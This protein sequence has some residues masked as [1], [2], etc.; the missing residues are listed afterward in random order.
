MTNQ[1]IAGGQMHQDTGS[2]ESESVGHEWERFLDDSRQFGSFYTSLIG[3]LTGQENLDENLLPSL[4]TQELHATG[5]VILATVL[6]FQEHQHLKVQEQAMTARGMLL[7]AFDE[8]L[9]PNDTTQYR[10][11]E[12]RTGIYFIFISPDLYQRLGGAG[13]QAR[14]VMPRNG[15]AFVMV[16][17]KGSSVNDRY[18]K[19]N[20]PHETQH[21]VRFALRKNDLWTTEEKSETWKRGFG[22][23]RDELIARLVSDGH[24]SAYSI[25]GEEITEEIRAILDQTLQT[26][27]MLE[28][29]E[30]LRRET[31]IL[32]KEDLILMVF[33]S[34]NFNALQ[35]NIERMTR[36]TVV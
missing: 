21:L 24:M 15:V 33:Q 12:V 2:I 29:L 31:A 22:T 10:I 13:A 16:R 25:R 7:Q 17:E 19:E 1:D 28:E 36:C 26:N 35:S 18:Y 23:F 20:I 14:T 32:Q 11:E 4:N 8:T 6:E 5:Q 27:D 30:N 3:S 34:N 9:L